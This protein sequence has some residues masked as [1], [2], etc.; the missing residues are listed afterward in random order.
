[1][2]ARRA[3]LVIALAAILV[4]APRLVLVLLAADRLPVAPGAER[5]LLVLAG[6]GTAFVLTGGNLYLAHTVAQVEPWR[7]TLAAAW[8]TVLAASGGLALPLIVA[9]LTA[10]TVPDILGAGRLEWAWALLAAIAHELTAAGCILAS[11]AWAS[12]Q[13][14][15][16]AEAKPAALVLPASLP[17]QSTGLLPGGSSAPLPRQTAPVSSPVPCRAGCGRAFTS[18]QAEIAHQRY[19]PVRRQQS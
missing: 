2:T 1:M 9:G 12:T 17:A 18:Q 14:A 6:I 8:L 4:Q 13:A 11:A 3:G 10:R 15:P 19:C 7:R 16:A 5:A